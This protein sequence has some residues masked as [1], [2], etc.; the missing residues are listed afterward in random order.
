M[1][2][3]L[4]WFRRRCERLGHEHEEEGELDCLLRTLAEARAQQKDHNT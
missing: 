4:E 3:A 1:G 2:R